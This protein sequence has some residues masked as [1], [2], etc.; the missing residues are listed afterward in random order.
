MTLITIRNVMLVG[1]L[2]TFLRFVVTVL[3]YSMSI[4]KW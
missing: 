4:S 1:C 3:I 2:L